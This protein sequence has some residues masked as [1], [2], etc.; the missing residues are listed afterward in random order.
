MLYFLEQA[1]NG[2]TIGCVYALVAMGYTLVHGIV[3]RFNLAQ[4][5]L[6]TV[7]AFIAFLAVAA[8]A[9][10]GV[11][12]VPIAL[13]AAFIAALLF[14]GVHGWVVHRLVFRP[15]AGSPGQ[16]SLIATIGLAIFIQEY[17]RLLHDPGDL[18]LH[19]AAGGGWRLTGADGYAAF[20]GYRNAAI[21]VLAGAVLAGLWAL[22]NRTTFGR[23]QRACAEDAGMAALLGVDVERVVGLTFALAAALAGAG[24]FVV[25][26]HYGVINFFMGFIV[27][28]KALT[29]AVVGGIGSPTGAVLGGLLIG[30]VETFWA[31]YLPLLWRDV[32]VF[33]L[34]VA[35]LVFRPSGLVAR[36]AA[37]L[38]FGAGAARR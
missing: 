5:E 17:V 34:L 18:W 4:G 11:T 29:A 21:V 23:L 3:G 13:P 26:V 28:M 37:P 25:A 27:G 33:S 35:V 1:A 8:L 22:M 14:G 9:V 10:L 36:P 19:H 2:V 38:S 20:F 16:A 24:G 6:F 30:L 7:G 12:A 15:L 31:A 32:A